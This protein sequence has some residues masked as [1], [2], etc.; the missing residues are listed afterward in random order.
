M[1]TL[2]AHDLSPAL[3][4]AAETVNARAADLDSGRADVQAD[5]AA[6]GVAG[7]FDLGLNTRD[8]R[9]MVRVIEEI[10]RH[11]LAVGFSAWAHRMTVEYV[12]RAP[13]GLRA[14]LL[15]P[16]LRGERV[17][18]TA[19]A[20]GLKQVAGLGEVP[21]LAEPDGRGYRVTGPIRWA[22]NVFPGG[23][24]VLPARESSGRTVVLAVGSD[25]Q[26][27]TVNPAPALMALG[28][29]GSTSV[30]LRDVAAA[31]DDVISTDLSAFVAGIRPTFLLLQTA[32]CV[33]VSGAALDSA[34][35]VTGELSA[36]FDVDL[37]RLTV[38]KTQLREQ[39]YEFSADVSRPAPA[40]LLRL[41]LAGAE[42]AG[43]TTRLESILAGGAGYAVASAANRRFREAAFLP[44][45]SP[46]E[47]QLRWEL[48]QYE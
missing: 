2:L 24:I 10:S 15:G 48:S 19:M 12:H 34:G 22:S 42:L 28:A 41:R 14:G 26:G 38:R 18:I 46:S 27:V 21:I 45:Q 31:E 1:T 35:Q 20:A 17:G 4:R 40:A 9:D 13:E 44:I 23:L 29:T 47:G 30:R 25:A 7:L 39:L 6:L 43:A 36:Q 3:A 32:F 5:L 16:L 33:G 11:S 37:H 8:L